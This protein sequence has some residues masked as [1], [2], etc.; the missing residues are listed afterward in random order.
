MAGQLKLDYD[1]MMQKAE[2]L[3][4]T[5]PSLIIPKVALPGE[6]HHFHSFGDIR[7]SCLLSV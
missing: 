5:D 6:A 7:S 2:A 1:E 3:H 4:K